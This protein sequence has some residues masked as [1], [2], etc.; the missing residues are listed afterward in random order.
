[1]DKQTITEEQYKALVKKYGIYVD[2]ESVKDG[3]FEQV[4]SLIEHSK[5]NAFYPM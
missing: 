5:E 4:K 2:W 1:M 3:T